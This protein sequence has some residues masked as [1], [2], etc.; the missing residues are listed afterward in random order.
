ML[1][2]D[3]WYSVV[4]EQSDQTWASM[5]RRSRTEVIIDILTEALTGA[6]KTRIMYRSNL[7]FLRFN[8]YLSEMLENGLLMEENHE[9]GRVIYIATE[10]GKALLRTL[11]KAQKFMSI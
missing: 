8:R 2:M 5:G 7:N 3:I 9:N 1:Q 6:N 11:L 4:P 10:S